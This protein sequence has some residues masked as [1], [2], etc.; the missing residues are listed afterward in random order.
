MSIV[1]PYTPNHHDRQELYQ[2]ICVRLW[3]HRAR[4]SGRGPL[5]AWIPD[6]T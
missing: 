2:E 5:S 3:E 1:A 6:C 4:Y